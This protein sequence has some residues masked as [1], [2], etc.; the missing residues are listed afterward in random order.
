M[1]IY[2]DTKL[3]L[4]LLVA[5]VY[6][7]LPCIDPGWSQ[8]SATATLDKLLL[9]SQYRPGKTGPKSRGLEAAWGDRERLGYRMPHPQ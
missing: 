2:S 3:G 1:Y 7:P 9:C 5:C 8:I 6:V 4:C